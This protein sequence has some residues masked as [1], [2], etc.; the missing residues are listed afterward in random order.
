[1]GLAGLVRGPPEQSGAHGAFSSGRPL[2]ATCFPDSGSGDERELDRLRE[3]E[4]THLCSSASGSFGLDS[5]QE[6][7]EPLG[8]TR[9]FQITSFRPFS[10]SPRPPEGLKGKGRGDAAEESTLQGLGSSCL[11]TAA[12]SSPASSAQTP[13]TAGATC[14]R[15]RERGA[16]SGPARWAH[17]TLGSGDLPL[18]VQ[19]L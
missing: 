9:F 1:M 19:A 4:G 7:G 16:R 17:L 6:G 18:L 5:G 15:H 3:K 10:L 11:R 8:S 12:E 2:L 14:R 13:S